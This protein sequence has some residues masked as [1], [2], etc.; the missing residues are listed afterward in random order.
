MKRKI[1]RNTTET[2][3]R[4]LEA[5]LFLAEQDKSTVADSVYLLAGMV[6]VQEGTVYSLLK[7]KGIL[8][9]IRM[10]LL[11]IRR[12]NTG[13]NSKRGKKSGGEPVLSPRADRMLDSAEEMQKRLGDA[14]LGTA[15]VFL[16]MLK[17]TD[18]AAN[19]ILRRAGVEVPELYAG[20]LSAAGKS[21]RII[22]H[23]LQLAFPENG[24]K[25]QKSILETYGRDMVRDAEAGKLDPVV[26]REEELTRLMQIL[27]R[28]TKNNACLVGEPGV[29]K[30]A[31]AEA[32]AQRIA[33][34]NVPEH[35]EKKKLYSLEISVMVAGTKYRGE[36][37]ERMEALLR[38]VRERND[39]ILFLD[40]LH[41]IIGAGGAEGTT[42]AANILKPALSRGE[43]QVIGATTMDEYRKHI[44][45][46]AALERRFQPVYVEETT[47]EET[48][49]ILEGLRPGYEAYHG[50]SYTPEAL[51]AAVRLSG[52]YV[53]D[54]FLPDKA[55]DLMDEAA[56]AVRMSGMKKNGSVDFS[57]K[58][59]LENEMVDALRDGNMKRAAT[60]K[61]KME[62][63]ESVSSETKEET[64]PVT[65][66]DVAA[67]VSRWTRIPVERLTE[68]EYARLE[69][70]EKTMEK[71]VIGQTE[72]VEKVAKSIRRGRL[73]LSDPG[74]PVGSFLF[75]GPTGVGKTELSKVLADTLYGGEKQMIR[76]DMSEYMEKISVSKL[77]GS[78]PGYVG[79]EEGGQLSE[80]VRR[81]PYSVI[82][83][84][85]VEKAHPDVFH[86]LLQVLDDGRITDSQGRTVDF[87]HTVI[88]MT[89]NLGAA[90]II[91]PKRM[92]FVSAEE[93]EEERHA[94]MQEMVMDEVKRHFKPEFLNRLDEIVVF[95]SLTQ[96]DVQKIAGLRMR[97][98]KKEAKENLGI[99]LAWNASL[100]KLLAE[101]G[102]DRAYGAR[103]LKR[104]IQTEIE[105]KLAD[106]VFAG[107]I[108]PGDNIRI[109]IKDK[110]I[111]FFS[112]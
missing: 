103:P 98:L 57:G 77:I 50:V 9:P 44:E 27:C 78:A 12:Q 33:A 70:L 64:L 35:L 72:A 112:I 51:S 73:G 110:K 54:R 13:L 6:M 101:K 19:R 66:A 63:M 49:R 30:T 61:K 67:A 108:H 105:D 25:E 91:D 37:E 52:R 28:R 88:I 22:R 100:E 109:G 75:L 38:E 21:K 55:I 15:H 3:E 42:D 16:E 39:V 69:R 17:Q 58:L 65:E 94:A 87:K 86:V 71:R 29:G 95:R 56:A 31:V 82:L 2:L 76:V 5:A 32:L 11:R 92:G 90:D 93:S 106:K 89:S 99:T 40:E 4:A 8:E 46:D 85:E 47:E 18:L 102:Y 23:E 74:R 24:E 80:R 45:K 97:E 79:Y 53:Q 43:L 68:S 1:M 84:D 81:N 107:E 96:K 48:L 83:F 10:E 60:L 14:L 34:G 111:S 41:T 36:F 62:K 59:S 26:G 7:E 20:V 104:T